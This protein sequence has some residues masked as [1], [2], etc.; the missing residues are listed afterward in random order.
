MD[1]LHTPSLPLEV[2]PSYLAQEP[3]IESISLIHQP[4]PFTYNN[5]YSTSNR[6]ENKSLSQVLPS[7]TGSTPNFSGHNDDIDHEP[8]P[9][10]PTPLITD[11][12]N[13][14]ENLQDKPPPVDINQAAN[15]ILENTLE[16][17]T[18]LENVS[19][20]NEAT[21]S[22][23]DPQ[24]PKYTL[25]SSASSSEPSQTH[26][27][28]TRSQG[29]QTMYAPSLLQIEMPPGYKTLN[30]RPDTYTHKP[31]V[32]E[33]TQIVPTPPPYPE[34]T[35]IP[36][37]FSIST[38]SAENTMFESITCKY[39]PCCYILIFLFLCRTC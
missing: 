14:T 34:R 6:I 2:L 1:H 30:S 35:Q 16:H 22:V 29:T 4:T 31:S 11:T 15:L 38:L 36:L 21:T 32:Y 12:R 28:T 17:N 7:T 33:P 25:L 20:F 5:L 27:L 10:T 26:N 18:T 3:V 13:A 9:P 8:P 39:Q 19:F 24:A 37:S 23:Y